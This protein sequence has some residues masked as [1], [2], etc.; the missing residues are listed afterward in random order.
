MKSN[1]GEKKII[2]MTS[3]QLQALEIF[4]TQEE[5]NHARSIEMLTWLGAL[6][7]PLSLLSSLF[8]FGDEYLPG[9]SKFWVYWVA[10]V[11]LLGLSVVVTADIIKGG[12]LHKSMSTKFGHIGLF[13][14]AK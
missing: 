13:N 4:D 9:K 10:A 6:F 2:G 14:S 5:E 8:F 11:P 7:V 3:I 1:L 12:R